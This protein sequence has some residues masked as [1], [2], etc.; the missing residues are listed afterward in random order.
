[1]SSVECWRSD[2]SGCPQ[3][4]SGSGLILL[5]NSI[6]WNHIEDCNQRLGSSGRRDVSCEPR[7]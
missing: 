5:A 1:M 4:D 3:I 2:M 6:K 7:S